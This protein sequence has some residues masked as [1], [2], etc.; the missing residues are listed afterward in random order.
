MTADPPR[1]APVPD[2]P[3]TP[4]RWTVDAHIDPGLYR[5]I[6]HADYV[7]DPVIGGSLSSSGVR[8]LL[9]PRGTP[10]KFRWYADHPDA[11]KSSG[12]YDVGSAAHCEVL[13]VGPEIV[14]VEGDGKK[15]PEV[16]D[17]D[18]AKAR[19]AEIRAA[20]GV[21]VKPSVAVQVR[22]M[23]AALLRHGPARRALLFPHGVTPAVEVTGVWVD[24]D[25]GVACR[26]RADVLH[27]A[28]A[29]G[30]VLVEYKTTDDASEVGCSRTTAKYGYHRQGAWYRRGLAQ[31]LGRPAADI[32]Y[33]IV[34]QEKDPPYAVH[35]TAPSPLDMERADRLNAAALKL[36]ATCQASGR[37]PGY[38]DD[39][40]TTTTVPMWAEYEEDA[41]LVAA[42]ED[43]T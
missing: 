4:Q 22:E 6:P 1:P 25:T 7:A 10:E 24:P 3:E 37:W 38:N 33:V 36:Y 28:T 2:Q 32:R 29:G 30:P 34:W 42:G 14:V 19:V 17:T 11:G 27:A 12:V 31:L 21:P 41:A 35:V 26:L 20:G 13:G 39:G 15:G 9:P 5:D 40:V 18:K 43:V 16:W 23:A 8:R